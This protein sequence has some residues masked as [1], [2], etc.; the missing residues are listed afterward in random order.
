M[1]FISAA[2]RADS[3][4]LAEGMAYSSATRM[5]LLSGTRLPIIAMRALR[6]R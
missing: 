1:A 2:K 4:V 6:V 5:G 3:G